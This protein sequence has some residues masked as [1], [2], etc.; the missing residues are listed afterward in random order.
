MTSQERHCVGNA[1]VTGNAGHVHAL[2]PPAAFD[3][4]HAVE[5]DAERLATTPRDITQLRSRNERLSRLLLVGTPGKYLLHPE[6][7]VANDVQLA[8]GAIGWVI[9]LCEHRGSAVAVHAC[10]LGSGADDLHG[11]ATGAVVRLH[12]EG[13]LV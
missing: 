3:H 4:V 5:V 7:L 10:E 8:I 12:D 13:C 1:L 2:G 6:D 11:M 9:A